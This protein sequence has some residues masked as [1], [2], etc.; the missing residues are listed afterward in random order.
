MKKKLEEEMKKKEEENKKLEEE[1]LKKKEEEM[2]KKL[3]EEMK[4][5]EEEKK[6]N[7][8]E[9]KKKLEEELKKKLEEEL[10]KK[11]EEMK[12]KEEE[13]KKLEEEIKKKEEEKKNYLEET[14][15]KFKEDMKLNEE[16]SLEL[17]KK[18]NELSELKN[19][20]ENL[21][22]EIEDLKN[23]KFYNTK[24]ILDE[25][26]KIELNNLNI[27]ES[28]P[29]EILLK[30]LKKLIEI[31]NKNFEEADKTIK[32]E[33][34]HI[35]KEI[36]KL[37]IDIIID[38]LDESLKD[39]ES[40]D[41]ANEKKNE[42]K[43]EIFKIFGD[44][45]S[46][47]EKKFTTI[48][49]YL[50]NN[51]TVLCSKK[52]YNEINK[53]IS[54]IDNLKDEIYMNE[55]KKKLQE[56]TEDNKYTKI[57]K[58]GLKEI[59]RIEPNLQKEIENFINKPTKL[60]ITFHKLNPSNNNVYRHIK[61]RDDTYEIKDNIL[62]LEISDLL[63]YNGYES[64]IN[65]ELLNGNY[66][67]NFLINVNLHTSNYYDI[68]IDIRK[69]ETISTEIIFVS[70]EIDLMPCNVEIENNFLEIKTHY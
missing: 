69:E 46:I 60:L 63:S 32:D 70:N 34:N 49:S 50:R 2:K 12:K 47:K 36:Y 9:M 13:N 27:N 67:K 45:F 24:V 62:T 42:I 68:D 21:Q 40:I 48:I 29:K 51:K 16:M 28:N 53:V 8:E 56:K 10:K 1:E 3:E 23:K 19:K 37:F 55:E 52:N 5:N 18:E 44:K 65:I 25:I 22:K 4:K 30:K 26:N 39:F 41:E 38:D 33:H 31:K 54:L 20:S 66:K 58:E 35:S 17:K 57:G 61:I 6:K 11:E 7:L 14:Q 43:T 64:K 59:I 15:K